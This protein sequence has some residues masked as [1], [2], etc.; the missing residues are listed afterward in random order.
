MISTRRR[1]VFVPAIVFALCLPAAA[2]ARPEPV[3]ATGSPGPKRPEIA[4]RAFS[5]PSLGLS[6]HLPEG[7]IVESSRLEGLRTSMVIR[8]PEAGVDWVMQIHNSASSDTSLTLT[9]VLDSII[10]QQQ[11]RT[12]ARDAR[13]GQS[14][15]TFGRAFDRVNDLRLG[16]T[17]AQRVYIENTSSGEGAIIGY[18]V[19][20]TAPGRFVIFQLDCPKPRFES[21]IRHLFETVVASAAFRDPAELGADRAAAVLAGDGFLKSLSTTDLEAALDEEPIFYR[22]YRPAP[23]GSSSDAEEVAWQR[24]QMRLGQ[25]GELN[26][27]KAKDSWSTE[28]REFGYLV[29]SD[30]RSF[31]DGTLLDS[32]GIFFLSRDRLNERSTIRNV[33]TRGRDSQQLTLTIV[34]RDRR[35]SVLTDQTGQ[36]PRTVEYDLPKDGYLSRVELYLL[37]RLVTAANFPAAMGFYIYDTSLG[38][39]TLRRES[40]ASDGGAW[41]QSTLFTE[42]ITTP[43]VTTLDRQG[44][45]I[46]QQLTNGQIMEPIEQDRL[47]RLWDSKQLPTPQANPDAPAKAPPRRKS[48]G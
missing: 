25:L 6:V 40:F 2:S 44:R 16:G 47:K 39:V 9:A 29:R 5:I 11:N 26:P 3:E 43:I 30:A 4:E 28:E 23:S 24:V 15:G 13:T 8:P 10:E 32:E 7:A 41:T 20:Q 34:R 46:R 42:D 37:P 48:G 35:M 36:P 45:I 19:A 27:R 22:I 38:K 33:V 1:L 18:T 12:V 14:L 17:P 31:V 21:G